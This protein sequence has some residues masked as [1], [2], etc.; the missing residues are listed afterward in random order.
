M[1]D[2]NGT[3]PLAGRSEFGIQTSLTIFDPTVSLM[4]RCAKQDSFSDCR[5]AID[6][7]QDMLQKRFA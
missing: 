1:N 4:R 3:A 6:R 2:Q 7:C 5:M